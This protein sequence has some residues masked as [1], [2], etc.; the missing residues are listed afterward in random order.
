MERS[1]DDETKRTLTAFQRNEITEYF[2]YGN[3]AKSAKGKN[4][5]TFKRISQDELHHYNVWKKYTKADISPNKFKILKHLL[6]LKLFGMTFTTKLMERGEKLAQQSYKKIERKIPEVKAI[7]KDENEHERNLLENIDEEK[8]NYMGSMILGLNDAL[9]EITGTLAGLS[10]AFQKSNLIG[11][12]G[13]ITGIAAALSMMSSEYLS[14]KSEGGKNPFKASTYTGITYMLVVMA[15]V[16]PFFIFGLFYFALTTTILTV[17][18][19][20]F[21]FT[22]FISVTKELPLKR[23]FFEMVVISLGVAAI[24]FAIGLA[25]KLFLHVSV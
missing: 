20:I 16:S 14:Q 12:V 3:L 11:A 17:V 10:L 18:L 19:I 15:L 25:V 22:Y 5:D 6:L 4:K 7:F 2:V 24:S 13:L 23:R 9:V 1:I 21:I 8:L